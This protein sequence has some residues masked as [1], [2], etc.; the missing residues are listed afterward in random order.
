MDTNKRDGSDSA[1][2]FHSNNMIIMHR[3][4]SL[5]LTT[6][7]LARADP[8]SFL[9]L[10]GCW[11]VQTAVPWLPSR[12]HS[13]VVVTR[14]VPLVA[15]SDPIRQQRQHSARKSFFGCY[16][17]WRML[18]LYCLSA[19]VVPPVMVVSARSPI[20]GTPEVMQERLQKILL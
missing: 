2:A 18:R 4:P 13:V 20:E 19:V 15:V 14:R 6:S 10:H 3:R 11:E 1:W 7:W 17:C 16:H 12:A 5:K 9:L 8:V